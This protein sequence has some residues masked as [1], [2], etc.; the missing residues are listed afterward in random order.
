MANFTA[1]ESQLKALTTWYPKDNPLYLDPRHPCIKLAGEAGELLDLYAKDEYKPNF[2][3]WACKHCGYGDASHDSYKRCPCLSKVEDI[4]ILRGTYT[5]K[6][7]DELGDISY[8]LRILAYIKGISFE[9]LCKDFEVNF[10]EYYTEDDLLMLLNDLL[11]ES[12]HML[13][14]FIYN[15]SISN[16]TLVTSTFC[17]LAILHKLDCTLDNLLELN[18]KKLDT[19]TQNGWANTTIKSRT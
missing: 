10:Q 8:Y 5:P 12:S 19:E 13:S 18:Y 2:S 3:W 11:A 16:G 14:Y 9:A 4:N 15:G 17:F 1:D 7:L 6:V